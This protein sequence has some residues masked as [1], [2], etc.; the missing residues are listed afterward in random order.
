MKTT[1]EAVLRRAR[2]A[3]VP[4]SALFAA[5]GAGVAVAL[6]EAEAQGADRIDVGY[7][8]LT[9]ALEA[10]AQTHPD[11][12]RDER[13]VDL[14]AAI[15]A[16]ERD[17]RETDRVYGRAL[18][19][20]IASGR[21]EPSREDT[22]RLTTARWALVAVRDLLIAATEGDDPSQALQAA[23]GALRAAGERQAIGRVS[24]AEA[25]IASAVA[26]SLEAPRTNPTP[27]EWALLAGQAAALGGLGWTFL[28]DARGKR[29]DRALVAAASARGFPQGVYLARPASVSLARLRELPPTLEALA[30]QGFHAPRWDARKRDLFA[31]IEQGAVQVARG[32]TP[33]GIAVSWLALPGEPGGAS[34]AHHR[35]EAAEVRANRPRL[36]LP[37]RDVAARFA[38]GLELL[39]AGHRGRGLQPE[40]VRWAERLA[41]REPITIEKAR[42]MAAWLRRHGASPAEVAARLR[43]PES[44]AAV[45]WLLWGGDPSTTRATL[46]RDPALRWAASVGRG[47]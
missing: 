2:K 9:L 43:D 8:A 17:L 14:D 23:V 16:T 36:Q 39:R 13:A 30:D 21:P 41:A 34:V 47:R 12:L 15:T 7:A 10:A 25:R 29:L 11:P 38:Q 3:N 22:R 5:A 27:V 44:P 40:T 33:E 46:E 6:A 45:A 4:R 32:R 37:P 18:A 35:A 20:A 19:R 28:R 31:G 26:S 1:L 42:A 24:S